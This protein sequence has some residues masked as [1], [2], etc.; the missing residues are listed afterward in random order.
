MPSN[1][2]QIPGKIAAHEAFVGNSMRAEVSPG[3]VAQGQMP[4]NFRVPEDATYVV[5]SYSTPIGW[6][7]A[8]GTKV[9][10]DVRYSKT[11]SRQ[12]NIVRA[13]M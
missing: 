12:Q 5:F 7:E 11:T 4:S 3:R 6:V 8:D 10:P 13:W 9:V 2:R 1:Y